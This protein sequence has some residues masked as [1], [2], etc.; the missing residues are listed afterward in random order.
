M[1][2]FSGYKLPTNS[3]GAVLFFRV[4]TANNTFVVHEQPGYLFLAIAFIPS[5]DNAVD[6]EAYARPAA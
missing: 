1:G 6:V 2:G 4:H 5:S 3:R